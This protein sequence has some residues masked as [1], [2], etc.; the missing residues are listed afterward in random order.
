M[1]NLN[2]LIRPNIA[3][4]QAY[5]CAKDEYS[6]A[7]ALLNANENPYG[8]L[9]R[10][11]D[12]N[13]TP[14]K[15]AIAEQKNILSNQIFIGNGSDEILDI[16]LRIFA[17]PGI[18]Q[19]LTFTP[20]FG[21]Y[22][23]C[24]NINDIELIEIPLSEDFQINT[25]NGCSYLKNPNLKVIFLCS[26]NNPTGNTLKKSS[27]E[28]ILEQFNGIVLLDEAYIDFS[29]EKSWLEKLSQY[30]NLIIS[31]TLSKAWGLAAIRVG[32]AYASSDIIAWRNK[33]KAPYNVSQTSQEKALLAIKDTTTFSKHI[34]LILAQKSK[35]INALEKIE[36]VQKVYPSQANF[37]LVKIK[38][39]KEIYKQ[40]VALN[41][42][43]R[44]RTDL[45]K[46]CLRI[47]VGSAQENQLL[48]DAL[49]Q[50]N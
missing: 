26:P 48:I 37:L 12:P 9:N 21:M 38:S 7:S 28:Y 2:K 22:K 3:K 44:N 17:R 25:Q 43:T 50:L 41:I 14:L 31:Q 15:Q 29:S 46:D 19:A 35:L 45:V 30:P 23:T 5:V 34:Q 36:I 8:N 49:K 16:V 33:I 11:P 42:I 6:Q 1:F 10:Y 4:T 39:A 13:Q 24:C 27:I 18:D 20:T 40:L 32:M 47:T